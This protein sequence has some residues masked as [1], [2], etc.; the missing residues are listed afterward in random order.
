[1]KTLWILSMLAAVVGGLAVMGGVALANGAPQE[2]AAAA[3]GLSIAVIP[4]CFAR[5]CESIDNE[6]RVQQRLDVLATHTRLL[7]EI[8]NRPV[9]A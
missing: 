7:A 3:I 4:Y 8:A 6:K 2:A 5:A 1:M 9:T